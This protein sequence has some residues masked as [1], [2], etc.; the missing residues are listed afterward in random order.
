MTETATQPVTVVGAEIMPSSKYSVRTYG[1]SCA[2][3]DPALCAD[4]GTPVT[5]LTRRH[6]D[7]AF[8]FNPP[9]TTKQP[10]ATDVSKVV[11]SFKHLASGLPKAVGKIIPNLP[12]ENNDVD[13]TDISTVVDAFKGFPYKLGGP[14]PCPS[15]VTCGALAC[16]LGTDDVCL[17]WALPGLGLEAKCIKTC[18][19]GPNNGEP[20]K[21][22]KHCGNTCASG[23]KAGQLCDTASAALDCNPGIVCTIAGVCGRYGVGGSNAGGACDADAKCRVCVGGTNP[24]GRLC[25]SDAPCLAD[26]GTCPAG[27]TC[28]TGTGAGSPLCRDQCGRCT[29]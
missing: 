8:E 1:S 4:V 19:N 12:E 27:G 25:T 15:K 2:G 6:G 13:A 10:N 17:A 22:G 28:S 20:C 26:G 5:M 11:D 7:L 21:N 3:S 24:P 14:C 29:P 23:P 9:A 16:P 18:T